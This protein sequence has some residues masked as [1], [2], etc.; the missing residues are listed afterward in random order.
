MSRRSDR[1]EGGLREVPVSAARL[2]AAVRHLSEREAAC[3]KLKTVAE[4]ALR[5]KTAL[6]ELTYRPLER[7][8][9]N[10]AENRSRLVN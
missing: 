4:E 9:G 8:I 2:D 1:G 10:F 5:S 6:E 7:F 3:V